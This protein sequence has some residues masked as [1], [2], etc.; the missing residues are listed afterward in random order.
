[1]TLSLHLPIMEK[2]TVRLERHDVSYNKM[3]VTT[4]LLFSFSS[5]FHLYVLFVLNETRNMSLSD[6]AKK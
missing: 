3:R 2:S 6:S 4:V 5:P 1:M